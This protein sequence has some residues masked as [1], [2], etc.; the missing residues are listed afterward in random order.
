MHNTE[1][2]LVRIMKEEICRYCTN[3]ANA[4]SNLDHDPCMDCKIGM[5]IRN[6]EGLRK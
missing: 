6:A 1:L 4:S 2:M 5:A 3:K